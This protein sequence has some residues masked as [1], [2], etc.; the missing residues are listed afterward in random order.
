MTISKDI[1]IKIWEDVFGDTLWAQDCFGTW[2][3]KHD[4]G[5]IDITR[6][7]RPGGTGKEYNY[8][9]T[10]DHIR[11][12][13]SFDSESEATFWNNLEPMHRSNNIQKSDKESFEINGNNYQVVK[14]E[15]CSS[16]GIR[17]Y[18]IKNQ[19]TGERVDWK[20]RKN[21]YYVE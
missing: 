4:Y 11:P 15:I 14:C 8:C 13:N 5:E 1:A 19:K 6:K 10:I 2:M 17:G 7:N 16:N 9:W 3:Y 21:S 20:Y 18:G 12:V